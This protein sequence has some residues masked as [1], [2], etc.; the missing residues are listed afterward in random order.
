MKKSKERHSEQRHEFQ[1]SYIDMLVNG[2]SVYELIDFFKI[3]TEMQLYKLTDKELI[4]L[5]G[6][7]VFE[8]RYHI[9]QWEEFV[10]F[11]KHVKGETK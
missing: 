7:V 3:K 8:N 5:I 10:Y 2:M 1:K 9:A 6:N 11:V 4:D